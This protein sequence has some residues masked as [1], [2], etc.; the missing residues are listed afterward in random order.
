M[1]LCQNT[2]RKYMADEGFSSHPACKKP[3]LSKKN[4]KARRVWCKTHEKLVKSKKKVV[5]SDEAC[6]ALFPDGQVKVWRERG[7]RYNLECMQATVKHKGGS[8]MVWGCI[9]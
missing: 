7:E 9:S 3:L 6:G 8:V 2:V 4:I 5:Y 1:N